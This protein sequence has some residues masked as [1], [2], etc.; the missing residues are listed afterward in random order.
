MIIPVEPCCYTKHLSHLFSLL[1]ERDDDSRTYLTN[2]DWVLAQLIEFAVWYV[3]KGVITLILPNI[4]T[5]TLNAIISIMGREYCPALEHSSHLVSTLN[6]VLPKDVC[7]SDAS[8][9]ALLSKPFSDR[10][11]IAYENHDMSMLLLDGRVQQA[12]KG[13]SGNTYVISGNLNQN[14]DKIQ[15]LVTINKSKKYY[16]EIFS[17][18]SQK[19]RV[20]N[21]EKKETTRGR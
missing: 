4:N 3:P 10:L 16:D 13:I 14:I 12:D 17:W 20:H 2:S 5:G 19:I 8:V 15:R 9:Q 1:L 6:L 11:N 18:V 21:Y 7:E